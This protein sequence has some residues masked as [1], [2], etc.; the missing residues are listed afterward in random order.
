MLEQSPGVV[1]ESLLRKGLTYPRMQWPKLIRYIENGSWPI[2]NNLCHAA[3]GMNPVVI[4]WRTSAAHVATEILPL[5]ERVRNGLAQQTLWQDLRGLF[6]EPCLEGHE[7]RYAVLLA[8]PVR[9]A[10]WWAVAVHVQCPMRE[11]SPL[12]SVWR[13]VLVLLSVF[14]TARAF[15]VVQQKIALI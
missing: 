2:S 11:P 13:D 10:L 8:Q 6:L 9:M 4:D 3:N 15:G 12:P 5:I 14:C 1:P 7:Q